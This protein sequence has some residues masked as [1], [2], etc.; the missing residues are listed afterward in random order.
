M[1][2]QPVALSPSTSS[3]GRRQAASMVFRASATAGARAASPATIASLESG[4]AISPASY[5][6]LGVGQYRFLLVAR[7]R[8]QCRYRNDRSVPELVLDPAP[9]AEC[10]CDPGMAGRLR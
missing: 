4:S 8:P 1:P 6:S 9:F 10:T 2:K 3:T 7:L 5:Q